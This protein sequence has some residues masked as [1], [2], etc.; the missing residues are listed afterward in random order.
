[1]RITLT[2]LSC[3][4]LAGCPLM[5]AE[6]CPPCPCGEEV[7]EPAVPEEETPAATEEAPVE[8]VESEPEGE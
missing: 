4:L 8:D 3:V 1:M 2:L 6:E 7:E 5:D